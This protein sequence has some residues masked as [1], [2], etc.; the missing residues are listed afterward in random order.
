MRELRFRQR[1]KNNRNFHYW[2]NIDGNW[3]NPKQTDNYIPPNESDQFTGLK[4][5]YGTRIY[6]GDILRSLYPSRYVKEGDFDVVSWCPTGQWLFI[7]SPQFCGV[8]GNIHQH[9]ELRKEK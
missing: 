9:P 3:I 5:T 1:N 6:E 7:K 2:G 4:D 8:I